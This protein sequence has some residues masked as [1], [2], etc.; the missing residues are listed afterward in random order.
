MLKKKNK[1]VTLITKLHHNNTI[2]EA[3]KD[4]RKPE[5]IAFDN[6]KKGGIKAVNERLRNYSASRNSK[7]WPLTLF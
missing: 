2:D 5:H 3:S 7:R 6:S 4:L 1:N